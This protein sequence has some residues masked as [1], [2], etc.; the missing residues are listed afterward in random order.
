MQKVLS[1]FSLKSEN[2]DTIGSIHIED[3]RQHLLSLL[4]DSE[5]CL[6]C[7]SFCFRVGDRE[8]VHNS[9]STQRISR[10]KGFGIIAPNGPL[11]FLKWSGELDAKNCA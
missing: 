1:Q 4:Y 8:N 3:E 2:L 6:F 11:R 5:N 7:A 9:G 10:S